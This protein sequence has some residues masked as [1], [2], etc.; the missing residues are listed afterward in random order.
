MR[1]LPSNSQEWFTA[2]LRPFEAYTILG[3]LIFQVLLA[4]R[5]QPGVREMAELALGLYVVSVPILLLGGLVQL[6]FKPRRAAKTAFLF[7]AA[8]VCIIVFH[9]RYFVAS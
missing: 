6:G 8:D 9:L 5:R 1:I 7:A 3:V 2:L 4:C